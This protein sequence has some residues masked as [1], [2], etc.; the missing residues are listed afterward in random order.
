M[1]VI[2]FNYRAYRQQNNLH[3]RWQKRA[4]VLIEPTFRTLHCHNRFLRNFVNQNGH[5]LY[6]HVGNWTG[7]RQFNFAKLRK[8]VV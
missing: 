1:P 6:T 2:N 7:D 5:F 4:S 3:L 8:F